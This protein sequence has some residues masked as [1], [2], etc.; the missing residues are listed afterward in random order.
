M[1]APRYIGLLI[2]SLS[3]A[4][5]CAGLQDTE[6][7]VSNWTRAECY[8]IGTGTFSERF[9]HSS[10]YAKGWKKGFYDAATGKACND[11]AVPPPC[12][13]AAKY[14]TCEGR[15]AILDWYSG[16]RSGAAVARSKGYPSFHD[17]PVGVCAPVVNQSTCSACL[18]PDKCNC[19]A[20][21][22]TQFGDTFGT[23][24]TVLPNH[25]TMPNVSK[26]PSATERQNASNALAD[27]LPVPQPQAPVAKTP[28][29]QFTPASTQP[30]DVEP[31][32]PAVPAPTVT[33]E[34]D[35]PILSNLPA[36]TK[37]NEKVADE[38]LVEESSEEPDETPVLRNLP[39]T[40]ESEEEDLD[41]TSDDVW[42]R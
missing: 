29:A 2:L 26:F 16:Y 17:V 4:S 25:A 27:N 19:P 9:Q 15:N 31:T 33:P 30:V 5:G 37:V 42:I 24:S 20:Q 13:W 18:S 11:P 32:V 23:D 12:Y 38:S 22:L 41:S 39:K 36:V 14:Q 21:P 40:G 6:Y 34:A 10:D 1:F 35:K 3:T 7:A 28:T 8:W